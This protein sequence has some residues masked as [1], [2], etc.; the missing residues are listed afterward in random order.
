MAMDTLLAMAMAML[1]AMCCGYSRRHGVGH[2]HHAH[3]P[4]R[5]HVV[6]AQTMMLTAAA[7]LYVA[8]ALR[9]STRVERSRG[10]SEGPSERPREGPSEGPSEE[11]S[12]ATCHNHSRGH[13]HGHGHIV[14]HVAGHCHFG[15][16]GHGYC[17]VVGHVWG[18]G[19]EHDVGLGHHAHGYRCVL[20]VLWCVVYVV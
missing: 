11:P 14:G 18:Y 19:D 12:G 17:H 8:V 3:G 20:F 1:L 10:S 2:R 13:N 4:S 7:A 16:R 15:G 9:R 6:H 5:G